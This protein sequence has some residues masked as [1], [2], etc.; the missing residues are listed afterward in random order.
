MGKNEIARN[1]DKDGSHHCHI[2]D[3]FRESF[4]VKEVKDQYTIIHH[5]SI[6]NY[7]GVNRYLLKD[8]FRIYLCENWDGLIF[9]LF[10]D[11]YG[12]SYPYVYGATY[13]DGIYKFPVLFKRHE[14]EDLL[15]HAHWVKRGG[16]NFKTRFHLAVLVY[17]CRFVGAS[18]DMSMIKIKNGVPYIWEVGIIGLKNARTLPKEILLELF[19]IHNSDWCLLMEGTST[20][21]MMCESFCGIHYEAHLDLEMKTNSM[22]R[23]VIAYMRSIDY[24]LDIFRSFIHLREN[25]IRYHINNRQKYPTRIKPR[26]ITDLLEKNQ[27][28]LISNSPM[29]IFIDNRF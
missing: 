28:I 5:E 23:L 26:I 22:M 10:R 14:E 4:P 2:G 8:D 11:Y 7:H 19:E 24:N 1:P 16:L 18:I 21:N 13:I 25:E 20:P 6:I 17:F 27:A 12:F 29:E 3:I 9:S 15:L